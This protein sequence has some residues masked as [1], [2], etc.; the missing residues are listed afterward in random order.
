MTGTIAK[1]M[2]QGFGFIAVEGQEK[3]LFFHATELQE[4]I[5]FNSLKEGQAVSFEM[6]EGPKGPQAKNVAL[7]A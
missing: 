7:V 6:G 3:D 2:D 4:G 5:D 1:L